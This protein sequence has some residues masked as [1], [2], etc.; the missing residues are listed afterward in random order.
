M[1]PL[2]GGW[3][4]DQEGHTEVHLGAV[5]ILLLGLIGDDTD[6]HFILIC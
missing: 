1:S 5:N 4:C 6:L 2:G 3:V